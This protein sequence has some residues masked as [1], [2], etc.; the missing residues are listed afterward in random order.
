VVGLFVCVCVLVVVQGTD[1]GL[2]FV[3][4]VLLVVVVRWPH[5]RGMPAQ[6]RA[7]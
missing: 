1:S 2:V 3:W 5:D 7:F 4:V 6:T